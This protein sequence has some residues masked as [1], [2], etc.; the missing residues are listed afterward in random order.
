MRKPLEACTVENQ[1]AFLLTDD[2][3]PEI[4][5]ESSQ[6]LVYFFVYFQLYMA[7]AVFFFN[8]CK[9]LSETNEYNEAVVVDS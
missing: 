4:I 7:L 1:L 6:R 5:Y 2:M 8:K 9:Q 3:R